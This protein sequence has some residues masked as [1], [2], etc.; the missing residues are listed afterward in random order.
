M[1]TPS[2]SKGSDHPAGS[3]TPW[4]GLAWVYSGVFWLLCL[5]ATAGW[6]DR[7]V[8]A[9]VAV[10]LAG[11][12]AFGIGVC[13]TERWAWAG[14]VCLAGF[15]LAAATVLATLAGVA[16]LTAPPTTLSWTPLF[17][18]YTVEGC[19]RIVVFAGVAAVMAAANIGI[20]WRAQA[21]F[22]VPHRRP[23]TVLV[24]HGV[25]TCIP[26][27][28]ADLYLLYSVWLSSTR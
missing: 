22:D 15:H 12:L 28:A 23:F 27:L 3:W 26:V 4:L 5:F 7:G 14:V 13:A 11:T 20:L 17:L 19:R 24:R 10:R 9:S 1:T 2:F 6:S 21:Q 8:A 18:G 16:L 25:W